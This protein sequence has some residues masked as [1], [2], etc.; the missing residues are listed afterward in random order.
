MINFRF[1]ELQ[2]I[3]NLFFKFLAEGF[4]LPNTFMF[5]VEVRRKVLDR[6]AIRVQN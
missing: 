6:E 2:T 1:F 3:A 4:L 5:L